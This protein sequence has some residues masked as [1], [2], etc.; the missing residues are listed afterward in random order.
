MQII[1]RKEGLGNLLFEIGVLIEL[2]VMITDHCTFWELPFRGRFTH[3]ALVLFFLKILTTDYTKKQ[4]I[5]IGVFGTLGTV[6]YFTCGDEYIVRMII[7]VFAAKNVKLRMIFK[8]IF[9][10][11]LIGT[12]IIIG[13]AFLGIAGEIK[14]I[15]DFG[16]GSI[17]TRYSLGFNHANNLH[18]VLWYLLAILLLFS[19]KKCG[20]KFYAGATAVN[21]GL[22]LLTLSRNGMIAVQILLVGCLLFKYVP[23]LEMRKWPYL[24]GIV[25]FALF[26]WMTWLGGSYGIG[27]SKMVAFLNIYLNNRLEMV[28][29]YAP[30]ASWS[31]FPEYRELMKVDNGFASFFFHYGYIVGILYVLIVICMIC[32][33]YKNRDGEGLCVIVTAL[34]ITFVESTFIFNTSLLCNMVIVLF[35]KCWETR[36]TFE[37]EKNIYGDEN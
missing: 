35:L 28:W 8:I 18:D 37:L 26:L 6:S 22:F 1:K 27:R 12:F 29:E 17:E 11:M 7:F 24:L 5:A 31:A 3:I 15:A 16:R 2:L 21:I 14:T 20:W 32:F 19:H 30:V 34:F 4:L 23:K 9:G 25:S 36:N 33:F 10:G 13:V